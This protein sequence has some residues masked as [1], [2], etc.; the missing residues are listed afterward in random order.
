MLLVNDIRISQTTIVYITILIRNSLVFWSLTWLWVNGIV[1]LTILFSNFFDLFSRL[2]IDLRHRLH[3][4]GDQILSNCYSHCMSL[5]SIAL[6][7]PLGFQFVWLDLISL[8]FLLTDVFWIVVNMFFIS[9]AVQSVDAGLAASII[10][11]II[12]VIGCIF[13]VS[14][15]SRYHSSSL[16][17]NLSLF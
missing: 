4:C 17:I 12:A 1:H 5:S 16:E 13:S 9:A 14:I 6:L 7:Y 2:I 10:I 3:V 11:V 8:I 15:Q